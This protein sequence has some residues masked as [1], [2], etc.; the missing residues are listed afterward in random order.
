MIPIFMRSSYPPMCGPHSLHGLSRSSRG[1]N[2]GL[3]LLQPRRPRAPRLNSW[4][5]STVIIENHHGRI[6]AVKNE[7]PGATFAF[8]IPRSHGS[9]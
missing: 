1:L 2:R 7:G 5:A 8:A 6:W 4:A 9:S 3:I